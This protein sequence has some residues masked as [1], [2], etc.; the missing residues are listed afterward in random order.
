[1]ITFG[2]KVNRS[3]SLYL[4]FVDD[5]MVATVHFHKCN[6]FLG[7]TID[8]DTMHNVKDGKYTSTIYKDLKQSSFAKT[9]LDIKDFSSSNLDIRCQF[10]NILE[11]YR[12]KVQYVTNET[13]KLS[14]VE[15]PK[16]RGKYLESLLYIYVFNFSDYEDDFLYF[17]AERQHIDQSINKKLVR[18]CGLQVSTK[19]AAENLNSMTSFY[20]SQQVTS[21]RNSLKDIL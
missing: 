17:L 3:F 8:H 9:F 18:T 16:H 15:N 7:F 1:M 12:D 4:P 5:H 19:E 2:N 20:N 10:S 14:K 6:T 21:S 13:I 11:S